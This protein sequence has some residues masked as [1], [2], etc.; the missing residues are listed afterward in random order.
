ML[1]SHLW[2]EIVVLIFGNEQKN[3]ATIGNYSIEINAKHIYITGY[4]RILK[5]S[6]EK[7]IHEFLLLEADACNY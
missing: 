6:M 4:K 2:S 1:L 3:P 7:R 5:Y